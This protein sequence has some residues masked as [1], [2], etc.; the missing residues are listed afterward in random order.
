MGFRQDFKDRVKRDFEKTSSNPEYVIELV[1][2]GSETFVW[3][4]GTQSSIYS[5]H[6][7]SAPGSL[8]VYGDMGEFI[9]MRTRDMLRFLCCTDDLD[10]FAG[11]CKVGTSCYHPELVEEWLAE[12]KNYIGEDWDGDLEDEW[13]EASESFENYGVEEFIHTL[14][15]GSLGEYVDSI[16]FTFKYYSYHYLWIW[17]ALRWFVSNLTLPDKIEEDAD[18]SVSINA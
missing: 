1:D 16:D 8:I 17:Y 18:A 5:F 10:Y 14:Y 11:K 2:A 6:V 4:C 9:W 7:V 13:V 12:I 3:R 15:A